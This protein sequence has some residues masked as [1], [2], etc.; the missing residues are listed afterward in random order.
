[1]P[2]K[3]DHGIR[4]VCGCARSRWT[5]CLHPWHLSLC[6]GRDAAGRPL[7]YRFSLHKFANKAPDYI[8]AKTEAERLRDDLRVIIRDGK[9]DQR[10]RPIK[11]QASTETVDE[12]TRAYLTSYARTPARRPGALDK[13]ERVIDSLCEATLANG[14]RLGGKA[15]KDVT[16]ADLEHVFAAR[17]G[18]V[19]A[20]AEA[21][22]QVRD[23]EARGERVPADLRSAAALA[24]RSGKGGLVAGNRYIARVRHLFAWSIGQ[25]HRDDSPFRRLGVVIAAASPHLRAIITAALSTGC[26]IGELLTLQWADVSLDAAGEPLSFTVRAEKAKT[27]KVRNIPIEPRLRAMLSMRRTDPNGDTLP[28]SAYVLGNQV[29]EQ[30]RCVRDAWHR[31]CRTAGITGL[32]VHDLRREFACRLLESGAGLHD[33]KRFLG[34]A[35]ITTTSTYLEST[36]VRMAKAV[37]RLHA[38][39]DQLRAENEALRARLA[40]F[41]AGASAIHTSSPG[42]TSA[43]DD[44][45]VAVDTV[46]SAHTVN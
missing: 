12:V 21:L 5:K 15:F 10:G 46:T 38:T 9:I 2:R 35:N 39:D 8:M 28:A 1:L 6:R 22:H 44:V 11:V 32:H 25:G 18:R 31:A 33:L 41:E 45:L 40:A 37:E 34:H 16:R 4:K 30:V 3:I 42:D 19:T 23:L 14:Q 27:S 7:Q 20:S 13:F 17:L 36:P 43:A 29:G 26:R 24:R